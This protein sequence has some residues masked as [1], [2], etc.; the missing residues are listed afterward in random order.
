M[1]TI[2][3]RN[4]RCIIASTCYVL[5]LRR[6]ASRG[7]AAIADTGFKSEALLRVISCGFSDRWT[8][9][10]RLS[11]HAG[12]VGSVHR[13]RMAACRTVRTGL[14]RYRPIGQFGR[15]RL[16]AG[17]GLIAAEALGRSGS[18]GHSAGVDNAVGGHCGVRS[19]RISVAAAMIRIRHRGVYVSDRPSGVR[20]ARRLTRCLARP[21]AGGLA[22]RSVGWRVRPFARAGATGC[23]QA[24]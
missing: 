9:V 12:R 1:L 6:V 5:P 3:S 19:L 4:C 16:P 10:H 8:E 11:C 22:F 20:S 18:A 17:N 24:S 23:V 21:A 14:R 2:S 15:S 13:R 7:R